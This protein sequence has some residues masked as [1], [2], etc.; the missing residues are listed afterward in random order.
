MARIIPEMSPATAEFEAG[1]VDVLNVPDQTSKS[2]EADPEKKK[3]LSLPRR[4]VLLVRRDQ[5]DP[6]A[7]ERIRAFARRSTTPST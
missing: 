3:L 4:F 6:R 7:A 5:H 1:N 2:W